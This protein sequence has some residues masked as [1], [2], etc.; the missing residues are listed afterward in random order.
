MI[1]HFRGLGFRS[2][3]FKVWGLGFSV[4]GRDVGVA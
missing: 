1:S 3:R 4:A 2:L